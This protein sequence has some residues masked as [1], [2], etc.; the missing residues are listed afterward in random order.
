MSRRFQST[1][2]LCA[3]VLRAL[4]GVKAPAVDDVFIFEEKCTSSGI[5]VQFS[6]VKKF[7]GDNREELFEDVYFSPTD[8]SWTLVLTHEDGWIG[9]LFVNKEK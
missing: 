4:E 7:I 3:N 6:D 5:V 1:L 2:S 8:F 9:P